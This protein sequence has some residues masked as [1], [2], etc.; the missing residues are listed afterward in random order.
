MD[1]Y[2]SL[3]EYAAAKQRIYAR[4]EVMVINADDPL[5]TAMLE[6]R[7]RVVRFG[8][9]EPADEQFYGIR[10]VDDAVWLARGNQNLIDVRELRIRGQHNWAN[11]LAALALGDAAGMPMGVMLDTLRDFTGLPHRMQWVGEAH[12]VTWYD[13]SKGT[14]VGATLA[15]LSGAP[16]RVVLIAGGEGKGQDFAPLRDGVAGKARAVVLIG[17]DAAL[18]EAALGGVVPVVHAQ[19]MDDAVAKSR[20]LAQPGDCVLLSPACASFDMFRNYAHRGE[21]FAQAARRWL[22]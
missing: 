5:V 12:G 13:D 11:A 6:P 16:G 9:R 14:N 22:P 15:A 10:T 17:R 7:R 1:R 2:D 19:D 21:V 18:I 20:E 4:S 8:L 3:Q